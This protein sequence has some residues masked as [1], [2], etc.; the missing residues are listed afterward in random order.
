MSRRPGHSGGQLVVSQ[1]FER[2]TLNPVILLDIVSREVILVGVRKDLS[3]F[4]PAILEPSALSKTA[5]FHFLSQ[6][7]SECP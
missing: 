7:G 6:G 1:P 4:R 3:N 2:P 5:E